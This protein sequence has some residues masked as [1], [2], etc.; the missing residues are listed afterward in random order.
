M[1]NVKQLSEWGV[2]QGDG[3]GGVG[4]K[5]TVW[6][7]STNKRRRSVVFNLVS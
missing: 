7:K 1:T 5:G 6:K 3:G 2:D 4:M